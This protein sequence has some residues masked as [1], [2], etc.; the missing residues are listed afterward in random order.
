MM[1]GTTADFRCFGPRHPLP[2]N[3]LLCENRRTQGRI[4]EVRL[5]RAGAVELGADAGL[6]TRPIIRS[7][8]IPRFQRLR[9]AGGFNVI[10]H[11]PRPWVAAASTPRPVFNFKLTTWTLGSPVWNR[12]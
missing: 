6:R 4:G 10:S 5:S 9:D 7:Q 11:T 12:D 2:I 3:H 8:D 1:A